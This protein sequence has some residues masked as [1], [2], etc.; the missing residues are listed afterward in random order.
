MVKTVN[1]A[2]F[3]WNRV[4]KFTKMVFLV[5]TVVAALANVA[6]A[7]IW[8]DS[9]GRYTIEADLIAFNDK[10]VIIERADHELGQV[11]IEKLSPADRNY[12]KSK[13]ASEAAKKASGASQSWTMRSGLKVV[14]RVVGYARKQI[15][16]QRRRGNI[17]V[18]DRLFGNLPKI[19]Q[20][21]IPKIAAHFEHLVRD[22]KQ[23]LE[24]WLVAQMGQPRTFTV[25][26]VLLELE[27]GDEYVVPFFFFAD[28]E[29][30]ILKP[31]WERW[32]AA[33]SKQQYDQQEDQSFLVQSLM[34]ARQ[35][36]QQVQRQ[37]AA[38][39]LNQ[40]VIAGATSLWEVTLYPARGNVGRP[41]WVVM[42]GVNSAQ[43]A[44]SA[45]AQ[46]PGYIAGPVRKVAGYR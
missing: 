10:S 25:D 42:P 1:V 39:Q 38:M 17:Y 26:G 5:I 16:L 28:A 29:L 36:D 21:M 24:D 3:A 31:G 13:E 19:Y 23:A 18:N 14:G 11:P 7:R 8:T 35:R 37:I 6:G 46:H 30:S 12:L 20:V 41:Q 27:N 15:T 2:A 4:S 43:A 9:T 22:D 40:A 33:D 45:L 44:S 32:I 34:A